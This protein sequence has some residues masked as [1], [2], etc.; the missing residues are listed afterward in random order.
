MAHAKKPSR[1]CTDDDDCPL[2][3]LCN[4]NNWDLHE[5][6][7]APIPFLPVIITAGHLQPQ[8][9]TG[10]HPLMMINVDQKSKDF[11]HISCPVNY[12]HKFFCR[13]QP[14]KQTG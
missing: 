1:R 6:Y 2:H 9:I 12:S 3:L 5:R 14:N 10:Q 8:L 13:V 4:S 7:I 11:K